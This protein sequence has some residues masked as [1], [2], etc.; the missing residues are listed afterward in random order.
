[1]NFN[2]IKEHT[3]NN[4]P[5]FVINRYLKA[6]NLV[7]DNN[8]C[9]ICSNLV[10]LDCE[11]TGISFSK[12]RLTQIAAA[13]VDNG[14]IVDWYITFIN[15]QI[16]I[17]Q[18]I[19]KLTEI[20]DDDVKDAPTQEVAIDNLVKFV[21]RSR[22]V[23]HNADFDKHFITNVVTGYP[24]LENL[25]IDSLDLTRI[26]LPRAKS[27]RLSDLIEAFGGPK[28]SHRADDDVLATV[29]LIK[30]LISVIWEMPNSLLAE[31][32]RLS[33]IDEWNT[34]DIFKSI[35]RCKEEFYG[36]KESVSRETL[37]LKSLREQRIS[38]FFPTS[39]SVFSGE[40]KRSK[41]GKKLATPTVHD[42]EKSFTENGLVGRQFKD[43]QFRQEQVDMALAIC[44][45]LR[46]KGNLVIE[47]G[48]GVGKSM[49]YLLIAALTAKLNNT[50]I[51]IATKTNSLLDQ[52]THKD[53]PQL[54]KSFKDGISFSSLKGISHYPCLRKIERLRKKGGES[55]NFGGNIVNTAPAIATILSY[56]EQS[57]IDDLDMIRMDYRCLKTREVTSTSHE[58]HKKKCPFYKKF[59]FAYGAREIADSSEIV[60]TNHSMLLA[61]VATSGN[62]LP[63]IKN[64]I[65]DEAHCFEDEARKALGSSFTEFDL[66]AILE[67]VS[68][69]RKD[70]TCLFNK[71]DKKFNHPD[72]SNLFYSVFNKCVKLG[73]YLAESSL[74]LAIALRNLS[75]LDKSPKSSYETEDIWIDDFIRQGELFFECKKAGLAFIEDAKKCTLEI[76]NMVAFLEDFEDMS[77]Y[78]AELVHLNYDISGVMN[79]AK[80]IFNN[81]VGEDYSYFTIARRTKRVPY[82]L[83]SEF[84][85]IGKELG[86]A[87][88]SKFD[89]CTFTSATLQVGKSFD[90]FENS[91]GLS[92]GTDIFEPYPRENGNNKLDEQTAIRDFPMEVLER[93]NK[94]T[95]EL[96]LGSS[97]NFNSRMTVYVPRDIAEPGRPGKSDNDAYLED[98]QNLIVST[99][100]SLGGSMLVLFTS[101][102]D[103]ERCYKVCEPRLREMGLNLICQM[104]GSSTKRLSD[105]FISDE[106]VSM[107]ALK[108]FW[109]GF[110]APGDTLRG[111]IIAKM[112]FA[113][114]SDPL[115]QERRLREN[116]DVFR[117]YSVPKVAL[118]IKQAAG[119]LIRKKSDKGVVILADKR[120]LK[121]YG[122]PI[123]TSMPSEDVR[124]LT[125]SEINE[126]IKSQF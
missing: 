34:I 62:I 102:A 39:A 97:F 69:T 78:Q 93:I 115:N 89:S 74:N 42:I 19:T 119:R 51:G 5:D 53:L 80:R 25:W 72:V 14:K 31:I 68:S 11:T 3:L 79:S 29:H 116:V 32:S 121:S 23:A 54:G 55:K 122:R 104:K 20:T 33:T 110:D 45:N 46:R 109:E 106:S 125:M 76:S 26:A 18:D 118:E 67:R 83:T 64:W 43:F 73:D 7:E 87:L 124:E 66:K 98:L 85:N 91:L 48:T 61:D 9:S 117:R 107:F 82:A 111:V 65:I 21:G 126:S 92:K 101:R 112:P 95:F 94:P 58:C 37:D 16:P 8:I 52:L 77:Y 105:E 57:E 99:T 50:S 123:L 44:E 114:P 96:A 71:I 12:D 24:L 22:I 113:V 1:M 35:I 88:Y 4:T 60:V 40:D 90:Y 28:P 27:H 17:P 81:K 30:I 15:P 120:V 108:T 103:M 56:V 10:V 84:L 38:K 36:S 41:E 59:C 75:A 86:L 47:A 2:Y 6:I 63:R 49:A 70:T 13:K 100:E